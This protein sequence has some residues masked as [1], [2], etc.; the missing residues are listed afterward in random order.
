M[1][2]APVAW[3]EG[4]GGER[5]AWQWE[6]YVHGK[7]CSVITWDRA[8]CVHQV[9]VEERYVG[10]FAWLCDARDEA[11]FAAVDRPSHVIDC[12]TW[13]NRAVLVEPAAAPVIAS[14]AKV[15]SL[16]PAP[17]VCTTAAP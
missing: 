14:P 8:R 1:F 12:I 3:T 5:R 16:R 11:A 7:L 2:W 15:L 17:A 4:E 6:G 13:I 10:D 9:Y